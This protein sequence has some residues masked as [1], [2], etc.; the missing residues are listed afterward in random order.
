MQEREGTFNPKRAIS[1]R[2]SCRTKQAGTRVPVRG[3]ALPTCIG[4]FVLLFA[5]C[6][7]HTTSPAWW[8]GLLY[9]MWELKLDCEL[10]ACAWV[11]LKIRSKGALHMVCLEFP[12]APPPAGRPENTCTPTRISTYRPINYSALGYYFRL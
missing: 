7:A 8:F 5:W 12:P 10:T 6:I 9:D 11:V 1:R 4:R 2:L 3:L